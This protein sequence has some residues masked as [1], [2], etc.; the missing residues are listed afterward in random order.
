MHWELAVRVIR[1]P[2]VHPIQRAGL[3]V[4]MNTCVAHRIAGNVVETGTQTI[5]PVI[6]SPINHAGIVR[7]CVLIRSKDAVKISDPNSIVQMSV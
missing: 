2:E 4:F 1:Y 5:P 6:L 7:A 3:R